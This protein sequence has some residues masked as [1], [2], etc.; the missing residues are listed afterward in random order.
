MA[1]A[2]GNA[3]SPRTFDDKVTH[4]NDLARQGI[5]TPDEILQGL[6]F[7]FGAAHPREGLLDHAK[8]PRPCSTRRQQPA[9]VPGG[10]P[11]RLHRVPVCV[12]GKCRV[13]FDLGMQVYAV[14]AFLRRTLGPDW[15][16]WVVL[17]ARLPRKSVRDMAA[18]QERLDGVEAICRLATKEQVYETVALYVAETLR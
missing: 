15:A 8:P 12:C 7:G 4:L 9:L 1:H 18:E 16:C 10:L 13:A 3:L 5:I 11:L 6:G 14:P 2:N 17:W